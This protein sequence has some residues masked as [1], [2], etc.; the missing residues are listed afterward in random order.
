[1]DSIANA[2]CLNYYSILLPSYGGA[3]C[4]FTYDLGVAA[5]L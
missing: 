4:Q 1:M 3:E 2:I 5:R